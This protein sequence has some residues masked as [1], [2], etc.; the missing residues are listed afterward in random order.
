MGKLEV[1]TIRLNENLFLAGEDYRL[2]VTVVGIEM[3]RHTDLTEIT[4][5]AED[6]G[7]QVRG[8]R[9]DQVKA[10][11]IVTNDAEADPSGM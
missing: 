8:I 6:Y 11:D 10:Q 7:L 9:R 5:G 1:G 2:P 4:A 3:F